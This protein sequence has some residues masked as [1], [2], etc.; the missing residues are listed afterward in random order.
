M[1]AEGRLLLQAAGWVGR[2]ALP[3]FLL[4]L[5]GLLASAWAGWWALQRYVV[6]RAQQALPQWGSL[7]LYL[8]SGFLAIVV[9]GW[10]FSE[11]AQAVLAREVLGRADQVLIDALQSSVPLKALQVFGAV[12]QLGNTATIT[13]LGIFGALGLV[14]LKRRW[15]AVGW[16]S[17]LAGN[18]LLNHI[19]KQVFERARP[20]HEGGLVVADGFSFPSGHSSG[21]VVAFGMLAYVGTH[22]LPP[23]W[24]LPILLVAV[25]LAF[26]VGASRVFLRVHFASDVIAGFAS[27][28]AWLAVCVASIE[29]T[30]WYQRRGRAAEA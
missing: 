29:F 22:L 6:P 20:L 27:G 15:L 30:R 19:L 5:G 14:A 13:G 4:S 25:A 3:L 23:R 12:T 1:D 7:A 8:V 2:H 24:H 28:T 10:V 16:S 11:L 21:S 26:T 9:G 18:G 17:A